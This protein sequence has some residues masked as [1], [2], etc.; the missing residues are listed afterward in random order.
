[1]GWEYDITETQATILPLKLDWRVELIQ[2]EA[3]EYL[4]DVHHVNLLTYAGMYRL[5]YHKPC[6]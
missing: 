4:S 6:I 2:R 5:I 1:M 3:P